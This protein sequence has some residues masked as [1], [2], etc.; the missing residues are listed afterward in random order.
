[1]Q[2]EKDR[3]QQIQATLTGMGI[4]PS[5][6][7]Q[8]WQLLHELKQLQ[9]TIA[10]ERGEQFY[11]DAFKAT[12]GLGLSRDQIVAVARYMRQFAEK[13]VATQAAQNAT[14]NSNVPDVVDNV[15][16]HKPT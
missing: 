12:S 13:I 1:M 6:Y 16:L 8:L 11:E 5:D 7:V 3:I 15:N 9:D 14:P 4:Q 2:A 10:S